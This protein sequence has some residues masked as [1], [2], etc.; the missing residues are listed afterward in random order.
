MEC[1]RQRR[2]R[3]CLLV[4]LVA[5][6]GTAT[7]S[8]SSGTE[9]L[10]DLGGR[11]AVVM[12]MV[13]RGEIPF[14]G[15]GSVETT[16]VLLTTIEQDGESLTLCDEYCSTTIVM[17]PPMAQTTVP[18]LFVRSLVPPARSATLRATD[19]ATLFTQEWHTEVRGADLADPVNDPL[20]RDAYDRRVIDQDGDG[21]PGLTVPVCIPDVVG[22]D[23]YVVH[24]L[25]YRLDGRVVDPDT[26]SGTIE[27]TSEQNVILATDAVLMMSISLPADPDASRHRFLMVRVDDSWTCER[28][29]AE[30][31]SL[32]VRLGEVG[33][34][35]P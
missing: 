18:D 8:V 27:W 2:W 17:E 13:G 24:R 22:G 12:V 19:G 30:L 31:P 28:L 4:V 20:P 10:P 23:T 6:W 34:S 32:L 1:G 16:A 25:R 26:V 29:Q 11:W 21:K 9:S 5:V 7:L 14:V 33:A 35:A 3:S 15:P